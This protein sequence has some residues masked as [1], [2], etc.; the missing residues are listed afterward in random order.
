MPEAELHPGL[1]ARLAAA[2]II[3][4]IILKG[5][6]LDR[7]F[8]RAPASSRTPASSKE[9]WLDNRDRALVLSIVTTALRRFGTIN[10]AILRLLTKG[11]PRQASDVKWILI[12]AAAQILFLDVSDHAAVD[13]AVTAVK[14]DPKCSFYASLVNAVLRNLSRQKTEI[15]A[16]SDALEMDTPAWLAQRWKNTYGN[17]AAQRIAL[18]NREEPT[19]DL[20]VK[21]NPASWA[22][23]LDANFL[24]TGSLRLETHRPVHELAGYDEG[25]WWVQDAAAALPAKLI[26]AMPGM[27]VA[28]FCAAPGGKAAQLA[29]SGAH[30]TAIDRSA[31][32]LKVLASN[33]KRLRLDAEIIAGD[34]AKLCLPQFDAILVDAPCSGTG[35]IRRHPDIAWTKKP[36]DISA[37]SNVQ[38]Q[39]LEKAGE[40]IKP[41]GTLL[42]CTCSLEP[43]EGE[44]QIDELLRRR[45]E[46]SRVPVKPDEIG[47]LTEILNSNGEIRSL[48]FHLKGN[49]PRQ[50][51]L[52]GFFISRL[53]RKS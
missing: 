53:T 25:E 21:N 37:L 41:G 17:A 1:N 19:L 7:K 31:E 4:D 15:K 11:F 45:P 30:V 51:G 52:D 36:G 49:S 23:R 43:E 42:Y 27:R 14:L 16:R 29:M 50:S 38:K 40:L 9:A 48:P 33:F 6:T 13:L 20:T 32:R 24:P 12:V 3:R 26:G 35:T 47:G 28:D 2:S 46:F 18:A 22:Q 44:M 8:P 10:E 5:W 39:M 34:A